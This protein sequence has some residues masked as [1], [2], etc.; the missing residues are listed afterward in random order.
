MVLRRDEAHH[1]L[2]VR[3][4]S[5]GDQIE[6]VDGCGAYYQVRL[7]KLGPDQVRGTILHRERERGESPVRLHL[8]P[9]LIKGQRFD[10]IVEKATEIGAVEIVPLLTERGIARPKSKTKPERWQRL[11]RAATK[12]CGR[13]R[14]MQ[15]AQPH[16]LSRAL[17]YL[18]AQTEL[19]LMATPQARHPLK[20]C[21]AGRRVRSVGLLIGPE[22]GF[23]AAEQVLAQ[24]RGVKVFGVCGPV[25]RADTAA[26]VLGALVQYEAVTALFNEGDRRGNG[27]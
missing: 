2:R 11:V 1:L 23:A 8:A 15:L 3:R 26:V 17:E 13:S 4:H 7:E 9:A 21:L 10:A 14:F 27:G 22:G 6:V 5:E 18:G 16:T 12:Q 20:A 25:M 24:R 19:V